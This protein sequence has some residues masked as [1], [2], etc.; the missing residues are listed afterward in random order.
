MHPI[1]GFSSISAIEGALAIPTIPAAALFNIFLVILLRPASA[2][3]Y[4]IQISFVP[5]YEV[6]S[7]EAMVVNIN[8]GSPM[9]KDLII[10]VAM[11][12]PIEPPYAIIP[13]ILLSSR[14]SLT[15]FIAPF[16]IKFYDFHLLSA[17]ISSTVLSTFLRTSLTPISAQPTSLPLLISKII[18]S[19]PA[20]LTQSAKNFISSPFVSRIPVTTIIGFD[21]FIL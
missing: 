1:R 16:V 4:I 21:I 12:E 2:I 7:P 6:I 18:G 11:L 14:I 20:S 9:G 10:L 13:S 15:T 5:I 3:G 19:P 8:L 17:K